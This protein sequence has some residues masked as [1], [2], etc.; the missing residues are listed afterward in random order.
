MKRKFCC[1]RGEKRRVSGNIALWSCVFSV[2][3]YSKRGGSGGS[4][5]GVYPL[6]ERKRQEASEEQAA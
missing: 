3:P 6:K 5:S 1:C 2:I 4:S